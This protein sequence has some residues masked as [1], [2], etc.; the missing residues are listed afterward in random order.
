MVLVGKKDNIIMDE[1]NKTEELT[2]DHKGHHNPGSST[3]VM[4][5][6]GVIV[7]FAHNCSEC[8]HVFVKVT[9]LGTTD[10]KPKTNIVTP[11]S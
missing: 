6:N 3:V 5:E 7:V 1:I 10:K 9:D 8:G 4:P 11:I 2:C